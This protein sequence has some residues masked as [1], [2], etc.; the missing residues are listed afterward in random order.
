MKKMSCIIPCHNEKGRI[1]KVL[2]VVTNHPLIDEVIVV[3]DGSIDDTR[4]DVQEFEKVKLLVHAKNQG[5]SRAICT[6]IRAAEGKY[7]FLIDAD[8][9]DLNTENVTQMLMPVINGWADWSISLRKHPWAWRLIGVEVLSGERVFPKKALEDYLSEIELLPC[10][11]LEV[12]INDIFVKN[13]FKIGVVPWYNVENSYRMNKY[14]FF[15]GLKMEVG[16]WLDIFRTISVFGFADQILKM[17]QLKV[18]S[19]DYS[20]IKISLKSEEKI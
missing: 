9:I 12:F 4:L 10:Y 16:M 2:E 15:S 6:G 8:L 20:K 1:K 3:D 18:A 7:I 19:I 13:N 14:G 5:K 17:R 11:G